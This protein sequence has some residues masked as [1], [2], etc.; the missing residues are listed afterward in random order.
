MRRA[1][2]YRSD[3]GVAHLPAFVVEQRTGLLDAW[4]VYERLTERVHETEMEVALRHPEL[5]ALAR[6]RSAQHLVEQARRCRALLKI[7]I[8]EGDWDPYVAQLRVLGTHSAEHG[9]GFAAWYVIIRVF[10]HRMIPA[11]VDSYGG[12]PPRLTGALA[13]TIELVDF[14]MAILAEQHYDTK[15]QG[16]L[17]TLVESVKDYAIYMLDAAGVVT[18]WNVGAQSLSGYMATEIIGQHYS[19]FF[20]PDDRDAGV[21]M[22]ALEIA[23]AAG[24]YEDEGPRIRKDGSRFWAGAIVSAIR[25]AGN[26]LV[27]FAKV[28]RDLTER[29]EGEAERRDLEDRFRALAAATSDGIITADHRGTITY[30]NHATEAMFGRTAAELVGQ[31]LTVIL[32]EH[33][34]EKYERDL[35]SYLT[36]HDTRLLGRTLEVPAM[37]SSGAQLSI[38]MSIATWDSRGEVSF[39]AI[40]RDISE[41]KRME[42][43]LEQRTRQLEDTNRELEAF[44]YSVAHDLRAPLRGMNGFSQILIEDHAAQLDGETVAY[45]KKIQSN[46]KRM[47][48]LIDALL[49][50]SRLSRSELQLHSIDLTGL[51]RSVIAQLAAAD[52]GRAVEISVE[53]R[54]RANAD[55]RLVR[56]MLENLLSNAWKFTAKAQTP[57]ITVGRTDDG[58]F[59]VRDN[60]A[61]FDLLLAKKLFSPFE[62]LHTDDDFPGTGIGLATVQRI[63]HRHGGRIWATAQVNGGATFFFTLAPSEH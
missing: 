4:A 44:S 6:A 33:L 57:R 52:P 20:T 34:R 26:R 24:R 43:A 27:G 37:H 17:R 45:L 41:R 62:R 23:A 56:T 21:P 30:V 19:V 38:E 14:S 15:Y 1:V 54:L 13:A 61:G 32:P 46:V 59:F 7:A 58:A 12:A 36:T 40:I 47:G 39:A 48:G 16:R 55:A 63:V 18:S 11:L 60:G 2:D 8:L 50:L 25:G 5:A 3:M 22:R 31:P 42:A 51:A 10:Q 49:G 29:R 9:V 28:V 53:D 35:A